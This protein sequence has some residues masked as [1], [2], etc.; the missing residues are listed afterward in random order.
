MVF[1]EF[2]H[3][4]GYRHAVQ[5]KN[6]EYDPHPPLYFLGTQ[7]TAMMV[8]Y[9]WSHLTQLRPILIGNHTDRSALLYLSMQHSLA[10]KADLSASLLIPRGKGPDTKYLRSEY[11][12]YPE[13]VSIDFSIYF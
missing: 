3:G 13:V 11:G 9:D 7:Y 6:L 1:E 10:E 12:A 8:Q 4:A 2:Y 5:Y